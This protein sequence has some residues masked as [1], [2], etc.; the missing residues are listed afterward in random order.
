MKRKSQKRKQFCKHGH[1]TSVCGRDK[2]NSC[3]ECVR[4]SRKIYY[5]TYYI[6]RFRIINPIC[7]NGHNKDIVGRTESNNCNKCREKYIKKWTQANKAKLKKQGKAHYQKNK[8]KLKKWQ[9]AYNKKHK[10]EIA[11]KNRERENKKRKTDP[12]FRLQYYLRRRI[13]HAIKGNWKVGSAVRDLGCT[14]SF[15]KK[16]IEKKFYGKMT[17]KNWGP[18]WQLD[19]IKELHTFNLTDRK[20]FLKACHYTNLQPLT[21]PDHMKKTIR[22]RKKLGEKK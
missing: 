18:Y 15:L 17:W 21:I 22:E 10:K 19:H 13:Y 3:K 5:K 20:Q 12:H 11:I 9:A 1:D 6:P 4:K 7:K 8:E 16:Y 14:I 2:R